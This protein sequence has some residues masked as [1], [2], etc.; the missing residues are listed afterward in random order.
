MVIASV[1]LFAELSANQVVALIVVALGVGAL[2]LISLA[3]IMAPAWA[4]VNKL[5]LETALKQQMLE[6]GLSAE[7]IVAVWGCPARESTSVDLPCASEVV[8]DCDGDWCP[9]LILKCEGDRFFVHHVGHDM[10]DNEW[11]AGDRLRFP[12]SSKDRCGS[13]W[14]WA[15]AAGFSQANPWCNNKAKP[16]PAESDI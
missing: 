12:A 5:R 13:P 6:R 14:D 9:A 8:V 11:V 15:M 2:V 16:A 7:E 10:S 3:G 4:S 1:P